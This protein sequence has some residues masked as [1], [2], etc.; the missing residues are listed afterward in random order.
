MGHNTV[1]NASGKAVTI[2]E[3]EELFSFLQGNEVEGIHCEFMP[4]L[5]KQE[6]FSVVYFLQEHMNL[7]PDS[8]EQCL[9][10]LTLVDNDSEGYYKEGVGHYCDNCSLQVE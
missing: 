10:C 8:V 9:E 6:A 2:E 1:K 7:L 3:V 4:T 5:T